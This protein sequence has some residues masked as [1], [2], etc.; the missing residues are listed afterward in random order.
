MTGDA[1]TT[2]ALAVADEDGSHCFF[3]PPTYPE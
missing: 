3:S 1:D 2:G